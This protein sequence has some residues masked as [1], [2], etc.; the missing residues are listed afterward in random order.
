MNVAKENER[1]LKIALGAELPAGG[2]FLPS[3]DDLVV[4]VVSDGASGLAN[5]IAERYSSELSGSP[6]RPDD[7]P[8]DDPG[9]AE[10]LV[11]ERS[12]LTDGFHELRCLECVTGAAA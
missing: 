1:G 3:P 7:P 12:F 4:R 6:V 10:C 2:A 8:D 11:C 5:D 9:V